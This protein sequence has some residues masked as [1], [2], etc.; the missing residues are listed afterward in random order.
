[1]KKI[2]VQKDEQKNYIDNGK[3]SINIEIKFIDNDVTYNIEK[4]YNAGINEF[5]TYYRS[6]KFKCTEVQYH[7]LTKKVKY[8]KFEQITT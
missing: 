4:I 6:I 7:D 5:L 3:N 2:G 1:M 8:M